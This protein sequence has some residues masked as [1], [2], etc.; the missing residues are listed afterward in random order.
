MFCILSDAMFVI[1]VSM[2]NNKCSHMLASDFKWMQIFAIKVEIKVFSNLFARDGV[3]SVDICKN[4][5]SWIMDNFH[6]KLEN[7]K[8]QLKQL[9]TCIP[10]SNTTEWKIRK[11]KKIH[12]ECTLSHM[13]PSIIGWLSLD[14]DVHCTFNQ[15]LED[16][17]KWIEKSPK[18]KR[19]R[20]FPILNNS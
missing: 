6:K 16:I 15:M 1:T 9:E 18:Y 14:W 17:Y 13:Q 4:V 2:T 20:K 5:K 7:A 10:L 19:L 3:L 11:L 8:C 12:Q